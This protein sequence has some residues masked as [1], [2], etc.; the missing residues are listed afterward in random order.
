MDARK[1]VEGDLRR[2]LAYCKA[3]ELRPTLKPRKEPRQ[4][5]FSRKDL[6]A[7]MR[8]R[9][10]AEPIRQWLQGQSDRRA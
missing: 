9:E 2:L 3:V 10:V 5:Y 8:F 6:E 7:L 4:L 1:S